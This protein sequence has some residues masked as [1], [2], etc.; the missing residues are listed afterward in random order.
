M[1]EQEVVLVTGEFRIV[2]RSASISLRKKK[3]K[4]L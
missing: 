1:T 3:K 2:L 4:P